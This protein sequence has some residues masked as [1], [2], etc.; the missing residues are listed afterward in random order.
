MSTQQDVIKQ[1]MKKLDVTAK[2]GIPAV[3]EAVA[4]ASAGKFSNL[5]QL[6]NSFVRDI[7]SAGIQ[8]MDDM[9]TQMFLRRYC[10]II[11]DNKDTGAITGADAGSGKVKTADSIIPEAGNTASLKYPTGATTVI[12]G[13]KVIWPERS[14]LTTM[15]Q[16]IIKRLNSWWVKGA[17]DL[18]EQSLGLSFKT[19]GATVNFMDVCFVNQNSSTLAAVRSHE[20]GNSGKTKQLTL[21]INMKYYSQLDLNN[22]NGKVKGKETFYLDRVLAHELTHAVMAANIGHFSTLPDFLLEGMAELVPGIDDERQY[23]INVVLQQNASWLQQLFDGKHTGGEEDYSGGYLLLRYLAHQ[24]ATQKPAAN[25]GISLPKGLSYNADSSVLKLTNS[26]EE[27]SIFLNKYAPKVFDATSY[28]KF[29]SLD[30][31]AA[32]ETVRVGKQGGSIRTRGGNDTISLSNG[33]TV[34]MH[35]GNDDGINTVYGMSG[36]DQLLFD[37]GVSSFGLDSSGAFFQSG[38]TKVILKNVA[39]KTILAGRQLNFDEYRFGDANKENAFTYQ[40]YANRMHYIGS[41]VKKDK[42]LV[43]EAANINLGNTS[44]FRNIDVVDGSNGSITAG[45]NSFIGGSRYATLLGANYGQDVLRA[46]RGGA[47]LQGNGD[48]DVYYGNT[49]KDTFVY[50]SYGKSYNLQ[51]TVTVNGYTSG[52]DEIRYRAGAFKA[53]TVAGN[54]VVLTM[55]KGKMIVKGAK[56]KALTLVDSKGK[57]IVRSFNPPL[58]KGLSYN[59]A[60]TSLTVRSPYK[61]TLAANSYAGTVATI[62]ASQDKLSV[63]IYGN[64][65]NNVI[66]ASQAGGIISGG[67]GNDAL[68]GGAG[69]D[70]FAFGI[71]DGVNTLYNYRA[72][73]DILQFANKNIR[74]DFLNGGKDMLLINGKTRVTLKN[75]PTTTIRYRIGAAGKVQ[76][77]N[78][79]PSNKNLAYR[80]KNYTMLYAGRNFTGSVNLNDYNLSLRNFDGRATAKGIKVTGTSGNNVIYAGKGGSTLIGGA[81]ND[82]LYGG[83]GKDI[84]VFG[85]NDGSNTISGYKASQDILQ[86]ASASNTGYD[87]LNGGKD[88]LITAG[89]TR[90]TLKGMPNKTVR[91]R[92]GATGKV[93][94]S[95]CAPSNKNLVYKNNNFATLYATSGFGGDFYLNEYNLSLRNFDGRGTAKFLKVKGTSANNVIYAGKGGSRITGGAGNDTLYGGT[96]ADTFVYANGDGKDVIYGYDQKKDIIQIT[97]GKVDSW[98]RSGSDVV[99]NVGKGSITVKNGY[100][101]AL[102]LFDAKGKRMAPAYKLVASSNKYITSKKDVAYMRQMQSIGDKSSGLQPLVTKAA[103]ASQALTL[104]TTAGQQQKKMLKLK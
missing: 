92:I 26:Y 61:G 39:N 60:K 1:F 73:Q 59:A 56:G 29:L 94:T 89:K 97:S 33:R 79:M 17:L 78:G 40:R 35:F 54:D 81:G 20:D 14:K 11:L 42:L 38:K 31:S 58:A 65:K 44:V 99:L 28:G 25:V 66:K 41:A 16:E 24:A 2:K 102:M 63:N 71:N 100:G 90:I 84:F 6:V 70:V 74:W 72:A 98:K 88:L 49:G 75:L 4:Y 9:A 43:N 64:A 55:D 21:V 91:Y 37:Q 10:G 83:A 86:L 67:A 104:A 95:P 23:S 53:G 101:K 13:L 87:Y 12:N 93:L 48:T 96:G 45:R 85:A 62:D 103:F 27:Q 32:A 76:T 18:V 3:D 52:Q 80:N 77:A 46:G 50:G 22:P 19:A 47:W 30:G 57:K 34:Y 51:H 5:K 36:N 8:Y 69:R 7:K 68:Y 82:I 15:Q